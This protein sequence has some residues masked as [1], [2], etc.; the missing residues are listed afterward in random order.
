MQENPKYNNV[1]DDIFEY[2]EGRIKL[3]ETH[4]IDA[5]LLIADPGIGFG[6]I[7]E[8]NLLIFR[9]IKKFQDLGVPLLLGASRKSFIA[10]LS[11][12]EPPHDRISGSVAAAL[13]GYSQGVN[14]FRVHDV[15]ETVQALKVYEAIS[16]NDYLAD[17]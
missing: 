6:K 10:A 4:R 7:L 5:S 12:D 13:Y 16:P 17:S 3:C 15:A 1:V 11:S 14:V 2:L 8:H 9:N